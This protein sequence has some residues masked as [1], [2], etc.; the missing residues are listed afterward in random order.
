MGFHSSPITRW[1]PGPFLA[2]R[3]GDDQE[4]F[5]FSADGEQMCE[6]LKEVI[7]EQWREGEGSRSDKNKKIIPD[8]EHKQRP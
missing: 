2:N 1:G 7:T 5:L 3:S 6:S 8:R 4:W